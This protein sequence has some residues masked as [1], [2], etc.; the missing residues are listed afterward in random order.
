MIV[1]FIICNAAYLLFDIVMRRIECANWTK[2]ISYYKS[3]LIS[4]NYPNRML[5]ETTKQEKYGKIT[6]QRNKN[7]RTFVKWQMNWYDLIVE[8][9]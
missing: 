8:Q 2:D 3:L 7:V 1:R 4:K 5:N 9:M 6:Y